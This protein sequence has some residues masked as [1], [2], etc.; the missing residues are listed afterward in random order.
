MNPRL[1]YVLA[2]KPKTYHLIDADGSPA[3]RVLCRKPLRS[4]AIL[5]TP[6]DLPI[7]RKCLYRLR[8]LHPGG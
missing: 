1:N 2:A 4:M 6:P 7:C 5:K 8:R 3:A